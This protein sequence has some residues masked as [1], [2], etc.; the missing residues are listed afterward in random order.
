MGIIKVL[1]DVEAA[2]YDLDAEVRANYDQIPDS[3]KLRI[4]NL[5]RKLREAKM[6]K[7]TPEERQKLMAQIRASY[8]EMPTIV[9]A[10]MAAKTYNQWFFENDGDVLFLQMLSRYLCDKYRGYSDAPCKLWE[11]YV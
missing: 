1:P 3:V 7:R 8:D 4:L 5:K 10:R 6:T 9:G 2:V 11:Q